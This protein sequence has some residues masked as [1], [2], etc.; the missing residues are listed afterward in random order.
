[1]AEYG[2]KDLRISIAWGDYEFARGYTEWW[3]LDD[4]VDLAE[5]YGITLIL[6]SAIPTWAARGVEV[7]P[8]GPAGLV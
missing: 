2:I 6:I 5:K 3:L 4:T 7:A 8:R 1:M